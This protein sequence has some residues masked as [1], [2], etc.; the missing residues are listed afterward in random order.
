MFNRLSQRLFEASISS[1]YTR[2]F[3]QKGAA[4]EGVFWA[5]RLSQTARF[6]HILA[7]IIAH[8][9]SRRL[10]LADIGCG[11]GALWEFIQKTERYQH[12]NYQ[13]YDINSTMISYCT[14]HFDNGAQRFQIGRKPAG[15]TDYAVFVG[16]FNL[17]HTDDY[18]LWQDYILRQLTLSWKHVQKGIALNITSLPKA[19]IH[20]Q[21]FYAEPDK[22]KALLERHFGRT[23]ASATRYVDNDMSYIIQK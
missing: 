17:C 20:N 16:T 22:F 1:A 8:D 13:G 9:S 23:H 12:F 14:R 11:Y 5:S 21:I 3:K 10:N 6:D 18:T 15:K 7:R 4:A 2:R 19:K